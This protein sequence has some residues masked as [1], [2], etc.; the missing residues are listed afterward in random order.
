MSEAGQF[1]SG[2]ARRF[3][4]AEFRADADGALIHQVRPHHFATTG[5]LVEPEGMPS[6]FKNVQIRKPFDDAPAR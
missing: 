1:C 2:E 3:P 4:A 6:L 5:A